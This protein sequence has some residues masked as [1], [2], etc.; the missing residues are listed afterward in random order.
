MIGHDPHVAGYKGVVS[1]GLGLGDGCVHLRNCRNGSGVTTGPVGRS[2]T[3]LTDA[4][5]IEG[6]P[7]RS[8]CSLLLSENGM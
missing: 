4:D 2:Q 1:L 3:L 8:A 7:G 5:V 6:L